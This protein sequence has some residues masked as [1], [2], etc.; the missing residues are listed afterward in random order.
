LREESTY[1][2]C[3]NIPPPFPDR[4]NE[5]VSLSCLKRDGPNRCL[6]LP[7]FDRHSERGEQAENLLYPLNSGE[8]CVEDISRIGRNQVWCP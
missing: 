1:S 5:F 7:R 8:F 3:F 6:E 2:H 4:H